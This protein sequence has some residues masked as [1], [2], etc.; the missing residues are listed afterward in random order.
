MENLEIEY[1]VL[2]NKKDF[3]KLL[4]YLKQKYSF[5]SFTQTNVYY[6]TI[7]EKLHK[8]GIS[9]RIRNYENSKEHL[10]TLKEK[11]QVGRLEHEYYVAKNSVRYFPQE[12][13]NIIKK[14]NVDINEIINTAR[15]KTTRTEFKIDDYL[16]CL[17]H[18]S[19]Y[20]KEDYEIECEAKSMKTAQMI[21]SILLKSLS[22][23]YIESNLSKTARA[24]EAKK[25]VK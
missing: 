21:I 11:V 13:I 18:S 5:E 25:Y 20:K 8:K 19:Y 16:L 1:K 4:E 12:I 6:D 2:V 10:L 9:L 3:N 14:N 17:D 23:S 7:D 24:K 15:L 22:I